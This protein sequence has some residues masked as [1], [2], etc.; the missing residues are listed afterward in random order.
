[1]TCRRFRFNTHLTLPLELFAGPGSTYA[2]HEPGDLL[3]LDAERCRVHDRFLR[4]RVRAGDLTEIEDEPPTVVPAPDPAVEV[5]PVPA[6][7]P[8]P[9][10]PVPA[11]E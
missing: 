3:E 9:P 5:A 11:K 10:T 6:V 8:A 1:M 7:A 4:G 2:M